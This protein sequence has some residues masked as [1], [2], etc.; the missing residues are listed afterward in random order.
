MNN[1][2]CDP[3][4]WS[5]FL[6]PQATQTECSVYYLSCIELCWKM[7]CNVPPVYIQSEPV[8]EG[9]KFDKERY[10]VY[11]RNGNIIAFIV[12]P[13]LFLYEGGPVLS[14]GVAQGK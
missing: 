8:R 3:R 5:K 7:F 2:R 11:Q 1:R 6:G 4:L 13:V 9:V 10:S 14:R 12:W